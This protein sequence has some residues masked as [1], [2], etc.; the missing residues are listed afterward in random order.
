MLK[1]NI[2]NVINNFNRSSFLGSA[3]NYPNKLTKQHVKRKGRERNIQNQEKQKSEIEF[4][5]EYEYD[6]SKFE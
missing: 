6:A 5:T 2:G 1:A 3:A 4:R